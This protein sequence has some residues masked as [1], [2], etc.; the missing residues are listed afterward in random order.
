MTTPFST[1]DIVTLS[2]DCSTNDVIS[3]CGVTMLEHENKQNTQL[4]ALH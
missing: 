3:L 2:L 1:N 4:D